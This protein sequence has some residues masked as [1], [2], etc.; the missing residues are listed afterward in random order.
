MSRFFLACLCCLLLTAPAFAADPPLRVLTLDDPTLSESVY[1]LNPDVSHVGLACYPRPDGKADFVVTTTLPPG[2]QL[3]LSR[4]GGAPQ[5]VSVGQFTEA[6]RDGKLTLA[7]TARGPLAAMTDSA[8]ISIERHGNELNLVRQPAQ[9]QPWPATLNWRWDDPALTAGVPVVAREGIGSGDLAAKIIALI[10][11]QAA[12]ARVHDVRPAAPFFLLPAGQQPQPPS[13][14]QTATAIV[15]TA[16]RNGLPA[17]LVQAQNAEGQTRWLVEF[18]IAEISHGKWVL[19]DPA[20]GAPY[21][22]SSDQ[23]PLSASELLAM[24]TGGD[25]SF[26]VQCAGQPAAARDFAAVAVALDNDFAANPRWRLPDEPLTLVTFA[27]A[28]EEYAGLKRWSER[29]GIGLFIVALLGIIGIKL[30]GPEEPEE[31]GDSTPP[32]AS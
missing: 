3:F 28:V 19:H 20:T 1:D 25:N 27:P 5:P 8:V 9:S 14:L 26:A 10:G 22:R 30:F 12:A 21:L 16:W 31:N 2:H 4:N 11:E 29:I 15:A 17:R 13:A 32:S 18:Y 23:W 7:L 24:A 6:L